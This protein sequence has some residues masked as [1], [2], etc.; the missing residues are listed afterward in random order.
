MKHRQTDP[1]TDQ[2]ERREEQAMRITDRRADKT[3]R[4]ETDLPMEMPATVITEAK[5][6][7]DRTED[8]MATAERILSVIRVASVI[9]AAVRPV[10]G[11]LAVMDAITEEMADRE[12]TS[13][14]REAIKALWQKLPLKKQKNTEMKKN[15][16]LARKRISVPK[17]TLCTKKK[18]YRTKIN[19]ADL[20]SLKRRKK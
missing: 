12:I 8:L 4:A 3:D 20:L 15:A 2:T 14:S 1:R 19:P 5:E 6:A 17:R 9:M 10:K 13:E 18:M 7:R 11:I 16:G